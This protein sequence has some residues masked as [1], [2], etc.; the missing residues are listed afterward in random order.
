MEDNLL[1]HLQKWSP[2]VRKFGL[3]LIE[4]HTINPKLA[5]SNLGKTPATAYDATHGFSDQYIVEIDVFNNVAAEAGLFPDQAIFK[6]FPEADIA[7][8]SINLLKGN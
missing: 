6:R 3:L 7:T 4:L 8:V 5:A 2:Y 1:E